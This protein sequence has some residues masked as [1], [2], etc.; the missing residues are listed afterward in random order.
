VLDDAVASVVP[1]VHAEGEVR[2]GFHGQARLDSPWPVDIY[3]PDF[4]GFTSRWTQQHA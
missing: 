3:T 1:D 2:F 4:I